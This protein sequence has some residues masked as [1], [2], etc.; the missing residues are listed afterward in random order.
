MKTALLAFIF[1]IGLALNAEAGHKGI[2]PLKTINPND[3]L[4]DLKILERV[5]KGARVVGVGESGHGTVQD[6]TRHRLLRKLVE[7]MGFRVILAEHS[8]PSTLSPIYQ[9]YIKTCKGDLKEF[10]ANLSSPVFRTVEYRNL[11]Q[12][13]CEFNLKN[14]KDQIEFFGVDT[15]VDPHRMVNR[16][17][18]LSKAFPKSTRLKGV[19]KN[20][21]KVCF[22]A[23]YKTR[24]DFYESDEFRKFVES[25][26]IPE[27]NYKSCL[28]GIKFVEKYLA[29][30]SY[31]ISKKFNR[32]HH[33]IFRMMPGT[34]KANQ[35][36]Y[37]L[38]RKDLTASQLVRSKQQ[39]KN[40]M[41]FW[42]VFGKSKKV[43]FLAHNYH[44][45]KKQSILAYKEWLNVKSAGEWLSETIGNF[46]KSI[47]LTQYYYKPYYIP[48]P[49]ISD[50]P[51]S[52]DNYLNKF[53]NDFFLINPRGS[54]FKNKKW[55]VH[56]QEF[57]MVLK[58]QFNVLL[59]QRRAPESF[60]IDNRRSGRFLPRRF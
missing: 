7:D 46:Y 20:M 29:I 8:L 50:Q 32:F 16:L 39:F 48:N 9:R 19:V 3:S 12:W 34:L 49:V 28:R 33:A 56:G 24:N 54:L 5:L 44:V 31:A 6:S 15:I 17:V 25:G 18:K 38:M 43:I 2:I 1:F 37:F 23:K 51:N 42:S 60:P 41:L 52:I 47:G 10:R 27:E 59:Y 11:F 53:E 55:S 14:P 30:N 35:T 13:V 21:K 40:F 22:G 57:K 36:D 45:A 58:R 26:T 4:A